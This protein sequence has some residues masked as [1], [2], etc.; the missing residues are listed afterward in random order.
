MLIEG[1]SQERGR[2][3]RTIQSEGIA[4]IMDD[5][6]VSVLA[7]C[8]KDRDDAVR[9]QTAKIVGMRWIW[10]A[11]S[12]NPEAIQLV[13]DLS[14]DNN[15]EVRYNAVYYGLS[16]VR[17]KSEEVVRRL[18]E[19]AF[20]YRERNLY[21][22]IAWGLRRDRIR[23]REILEE[24]IDG[25]DHVQAKYAREVYEDMTGRKRPKG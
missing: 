24:Y 9:R 13:L 11:H 7:A 10:S 14:R 1:N 15:Q 18:L 25:P 23:V 20:E 2:E 6:F 12:Q 21:R 16:T 22:R 19:M 4:L 3:L 8:G 5:S 17:R